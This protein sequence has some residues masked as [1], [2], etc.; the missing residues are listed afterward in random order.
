MNRKE[1]Y[2]F[3]IE[4]FCNILSFYCHFWSIEYVLVEY[5]FLSKKNDDFFFL[6]EMNTCSI[7]WVNDGRILIPDKLFSFSI[8]C[9]QKYLKQGRSQEGTNVYNNL[10]TQ[11]L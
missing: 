6:K 1:H 7:I 9:E 5:S 3:E 11:H 8:Y 10:F 2:L 4:I